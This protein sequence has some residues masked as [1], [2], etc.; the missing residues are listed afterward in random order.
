MVTVP[1]PMWGSGA[2]SF[3]H[4]TADAFVALALPLSLQHFTS[5]AAIALWPAS[6]EVFPTSS[7]R[8]GFN[9]LRFSDFYLGV[10]SLVTDN[11]QT[12]VNCTYKYQIKYL[13]EPD[14]AVTFSEVCAGKCGKMFGKVIITL[15]KLYII[16]S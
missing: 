14:R 2:S 13:T 4:W 5:A 8:T 3:A 7:T 10:K 16:Y 12:T 1:G 15:L 9:L 11:V 6:G